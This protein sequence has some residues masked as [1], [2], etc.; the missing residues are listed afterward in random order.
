[1][2]ITKEQIQQGRKKMSAEE[3]QQH[4]KNTR[5]G[6]GVQQNKKKYN[7]KDKHKSLQY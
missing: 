6:V 7:R 1:M 3:L 2:K 5:Q 4:I